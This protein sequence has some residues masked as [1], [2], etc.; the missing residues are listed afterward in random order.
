MSPRT[1]WPL[2]VGACLTASLVF[3][4]LGIWQLGQLRARQAVSRLAVAAREMPVVPLD[5]PVAAASLARSGAD[6]RR[7][8]VTGRYDHAA[9]IVLRGQRER[10]VPGLRIVTPLRPLRGDTAVLVQRGFVASPDGRTARISA[11][12]EPGVREVVGVAT[13]L[14][15]S[16]VAGEPAEEEGQ[17]TWRRL[18]LGAV[19][20]RLP[21]PVHQFLLLQLPDTALPAVPRRDTPPELSDGPH[22]G[23]ALIWFSLAAIALAA[24]A[25]GWLRRKSGTDPAPQRPPSS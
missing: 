11:L 22:I 13:V 18:D 6:H 7:V 14:P 12:E 17:L 2:L 20:E 8:R 24:G 16:G 4:R 10:G 23:Y 15:D 5:D 1:W 19:R 21:Y 9:E 3:A 25:L